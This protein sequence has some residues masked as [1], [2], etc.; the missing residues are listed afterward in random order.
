[1]N[2]LVIP[3]LII[4][5]TIDYIATQF[6]AAPRALTWL[7]EVYSGLILLV[8]V[9]R[10]VTGQKLDV[11]AKY[12]LWAA[13][14]IMLIL[15]GV[16]LNQVQPGAVFSGARN[17]FRYMP[18]FLLPMAFPFSEQQLKT[19]L[20]WLLGLLVVQVRS[21]FTSVLSSSQA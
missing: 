19:Q 9:A 6:P 12:A 3:F 14:M 20:M 13:G 16:L 17:Y 21:L 4:V 2:K 15:A 1:M 10:L 8:V 5:F 18:V 7:P 11:P